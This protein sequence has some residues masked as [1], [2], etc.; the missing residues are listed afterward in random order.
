VPTKRWVSYTEVDI[1]GSSVAMTM[2]NTAEYNVIVY[3]IWYTIT[4]LCRSHCVYYM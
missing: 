1:V 4:L 3:I 2:L